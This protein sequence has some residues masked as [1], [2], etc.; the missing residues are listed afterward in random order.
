MTKQ[1]VLI[2]IIVILLVA[3]GVIIWM[4]NSKEIIAP[5]VSNTTQNTNSDV[6]P[7]NSNSNGAEIMPINENEE[8]EKELEANGNN[9]L[10]SKVTVNQKAV[11]MSMNVPAP[12]T[13]QFDTTNNT[14]KG[15]GGCNNFSGTY[16]S[17]DNYVF[18]FGATV[19]TKMACPVTMELENS[20]FK[21][22]DDA[23]SY[24]V[25]GNALV[26][27]SK[28]GYTELVYTPAI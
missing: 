7:T 12:L 5:E 2:T 18:D 28:D 22:M 23:V 6:E 19:S 8:F 1:N 9:W 26:F 21:A 3:I 15:F 25:K 11:D 14:Y 16:T 13:L 17:A 10:L 27:T 20:I 4:N 24:G